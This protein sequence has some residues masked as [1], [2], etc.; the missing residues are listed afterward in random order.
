MGTNQYSVIEADG[1]TL[2]VLAPDEETARMAAPKEGRAIYCDGVI[3]L[4]GKDGAWH[5]WAT[6]PF[7]G[8]IR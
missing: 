6:V 5:H 3:K 1:V 2:A 7:T 8:R 4:V